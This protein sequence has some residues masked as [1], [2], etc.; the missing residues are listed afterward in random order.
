MSCGGSFGPHD[1]RRWRRTWGG[2]LIGLVLTIAGTIAF[3]AGMV[4]L[5]RG[6]PGYRVGRLLS[7]ATPLTLEE[8]AAAAASG[9]QRYVRTRGRI[10]SDEEFPDENDRPLVYR[11]QRLQSGAGRRGWTDV[12]DDRVAVPFGVEERGAF[13]AIDVDALGEG[14]VVVPRVAEGTAADLPATWAERV[15]RMDPTTRVRLRVDQLSAVEQATAAG[16]PIMGK[17]GAPLLTAGL[18]RPL[19]VS[20]LEPDA[21]M[22]VLAS[23]RRTAVRLAAG[24]LVAGLALV[25]VGVV[26]F[27]AHL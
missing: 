15:P 6:G 26:A 13:L 11:R 23:E 14:L 19:I 9:E 24:L 8:V 4:L 22:R 21:A 12:D 27:L 2:R 1:S 3:V 7:V 18:G 10:A 5:N 20:P 17:N 25:A 16:V